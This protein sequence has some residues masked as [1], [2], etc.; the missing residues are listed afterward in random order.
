MPPLSFS[1]CQGKESK[2]ATKGETVGPGESQ[3]A[4]LW[5]IG[6]AGLDWPL[7]VYSGYDFIRSGCPADPAGKIT[8]SISGGPAF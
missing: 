2:A 7:G 1:V 8:E 4:G 6:I 5:W 3:C